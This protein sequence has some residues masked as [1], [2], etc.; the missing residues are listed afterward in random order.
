MRQ[1]LLLGANPRRA[2]DRMSENLD[3]V[4]S[5]FPKL[6]E[7]QRQRVRTMSGGERQMV[8]IGRALMS[9]P[10]YL[11]LDEPSLGLSP[12][13]CGEL[14][15]SFEQIKQAG[16]GVLLVE[17]NAKRSLDIADRGYLLEIG[18]IV[19][20]GT[21]AQLRDNEDVQRAYLGYARKTS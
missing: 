18:H 9:S 13:L 5:L 4:I 2:R 15:K 6:G 21:A 16:V 8:A 17:Q 20:A 12:I 11:L 1:N 10:D 7:R 19:G 3:R 14:F